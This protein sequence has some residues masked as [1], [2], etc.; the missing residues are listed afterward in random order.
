MQEIRAKIVERLKG[1]TTLMSLAT[2][3]VW[4]RKL[5]YGKG[6]PGNTNAA[7]YILPPSQ[8]PTQKVRLHPA[9]YVGPPNDVDSTDGNQEDG[10]VQ[11]RWAFLRLYY[12]VPATGSGK[13]E[14]DQI[15]A[16]VRWLLS[17]VRWQPVLSNG[18][19]LT[20]TSLELPELTDSDEWEGS[21]VTYRR[22]RGEYLRP[23][24]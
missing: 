19:V 1:D 18:A 13:E 2:G 21:L 16:R 11:N 24:P 22:F 6:L 4:D 7:F 8:D 12:Y 10:R 14:L 23:E 15:D 5:S 17:P 9:I 3:S 20:M